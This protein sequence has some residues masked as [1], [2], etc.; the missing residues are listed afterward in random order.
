MKNL[1]KIKR[2]LSR[3]RIS[4]NYDDE[5]FNDEMPSVNRLFGL[6]DLL[7]FYNAS[8]N[9]KVIEIGSY[10]GASAE[11]IAQYVGEVICCD[12]WEKY[13]TPFER[14]LKAYNNFKKTKKRN[15]N[16]I[17]LKINSEEIVN[18]YKNNTFDM[19]YIDSDHSY[20]TTKNNIL[21]WFCKVKKGGIVCGHDYHMPSVKLAVDEV[22]GS[23]NIKIF[24]DSSWA[25]LK[26]NRENKKFSIIIPT[27]KRTEL[28]NFAM[29]SVKDQNYE[30]YE[31]IVCSDGYSKE[32]EECVL[33]MKDSRFTYDFIEKIQ[34]DNFGHMQRNFVIPRCTGDYTI[35]LDDDNFFEKDY[36]L[37]S[38]NQINDDCGMLVFKI[39][40]LHGVLPIGD[41]KLVH[42]NID[43]LNVMVRT[44]L[45]KVV[46]WGLKYDSD[47]YFIKEI[48]KL[49]LEKKLKIVFFEKIIGTHR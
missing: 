5:Y 32:D 35:W 14:F 36:L 40:H 39:K 24:K 38:N 9:W 4:D 45:A 47:F 17:E 3:Y 46:K 37:F 12:I 25:Y 29:N 2:I 11:L 19:V 22:L 27:Y 6:M 33:N 26:N 49:C 43:T 30:N 15:S 23:K 44:D 28:L 34:I 48:E 21:T 13:I 20:S 1:S 8:E 41:S 18:N 42:G 31:V 10:A 16:I 7:E